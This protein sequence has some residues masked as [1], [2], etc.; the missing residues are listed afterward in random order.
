MAEEYQREIAAF[1]K[2][3]PDPNTA[4]SAADILLDKLSPRLPGSG[5]ISVLTA[6]NVNTEADTALTDYDPPT[7]A[8][9]DAKI[10]ALSLLSDKEKA[11]IGITGQ[12]FLKDH[13]LTV[14]YQADPSTDNWTVIE[15]SGS[16]VLVDAATSLSF[17]KVQAGAIA[18]HDAVVH[19]GTKKHWDSVKETKTVNVRCKFKVEDLTGEFCLGLYS[20]NTAVH[21]PTAETYDYIWRNVAGLHGDNDVIDAVTQAGTDI[22]AEITDISAS[23]ANSTWYELEITETSTSVIFKINGVTVATHSTQVA[24]LPQCFAASAKNT[25]GINTMLAIQ[26]VEVWVT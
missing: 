13:F 5:T 25:N 18:T 10:D 11:F 2:A 6:A 22:A 1:N 12:P 21:V 7:K 14:A 20:T 16:T 4:N 9:M 15:D 23:L 24:T 17:L 8:E 26:Y 3:L 19:T